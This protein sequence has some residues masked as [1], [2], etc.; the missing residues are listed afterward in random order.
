MI[1]SQIWYLSEVVLWCVI[2]SSALSRVRNH[3]MD[4]TGN[5][6]KHSELVSVQHQ[7]DQ[8]VVISSQQACQHE[9]KQDRPRSGE[10]QLSWCEIGETPSAGQTSFLLCFFQPRPPSLIKD[11]QYLYFNK[12][13]NWHWHIQPYCIHNAH[14]FSFLTCD[15]MVLNLSFSEDFKILVTC[16]KISV[17]D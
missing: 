5:P 13:F 16:L 7:A 11:T 4:P 12:G 15:L 17:D 10:S 8:K 6:G 1:W 14:L 2:S 9:L 3:T